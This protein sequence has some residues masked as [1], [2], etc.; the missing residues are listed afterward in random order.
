LFLRARSISFA[1]GDCHFWTLL[2]PS[3]SDLLYG[4]RSFEFFV[5]FTFSLRSPEPMTDWGIFHCASNAATVRRNHM[6]KIILAAGL[7]AASFGATVFAQET[8][9]DDATI[10]KMDGEIAAMKEE[11]RTAPTKEMAMAKSA[12][13]AKNMDECK[14]HLNNAMAAMKK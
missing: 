1:G 8:A 12:M 3:I 6:W 11:D 13:M 2:L 9:C 14:T 10:A 4:Q 5:I 7:L